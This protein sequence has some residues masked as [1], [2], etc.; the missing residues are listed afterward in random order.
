MEEL[1]RIN[2]KLARKQIVRIV[3][4]VGS[5]ALGSIL[6]GRCIYQKGVT[7][8]QCWIAK[9]YPEEYASMTR[10]VVKQLENS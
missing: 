4:G 5:L 7:D 1:K 9:A 2:A 10:K 3:G 6:I 8:C